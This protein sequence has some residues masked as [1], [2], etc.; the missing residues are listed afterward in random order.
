M[1]SMASFWN[2]EAELARLRSLL[3]KGALAYVTG[4]RRLGKTAL[5]TKACA[6]FGGLY[7]QAVEGTAQQQ[8]EHLALEWKD[9]LP[10]LRDLTPRQ[11]EIFCRS[12]Y[13]GSARYWE[14][15]VELDLVAYQKA[16]KNHL[17]GECKWSDL[18]GQEEKKLEE[19]LRQ[20]FS[21]TK[22][23]G[24]FPEVEFRIFSKKDFAANLFRRC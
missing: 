3:G 6:D 20:R 9:R 4:R 10:L 5:L 18:T 19:D 14:G 7:H 23:T 11:W 12:F 15:E 2:R 17:V 21:R 24:R 16:K 8:I 22:L 1:L 13:P